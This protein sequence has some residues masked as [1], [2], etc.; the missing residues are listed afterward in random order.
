MLSPESILALFERHGARQYDGDGV[1]QLQHAW[2][3]G[4][5]AARAGAPPSLQLAAWLHDLGHLMSDLAGSPTTR[6]LDDRHETLAGD[7]LRPIF[8]DAVAGPVQQHVQA[9][10]CLVATHLGYRDRLSMDS[11]RSLALQ[12]GPMTADDAADFIRR[13]HAQD[14]LRL[15][16]WDDAAKVAALQPHD[17]TLALRKLAELM[18]RHAASTSV[19]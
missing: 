18:A 8:G 15:R 7:L 11:V 19:R 5:L 2:Q 13:P 12:G 17:A 14:A 10:R 4:R 9:K 6:G 3:C 1:T 16:A